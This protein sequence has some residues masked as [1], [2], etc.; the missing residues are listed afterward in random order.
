MTSAGSQQRAEN[1]GHQLS[2]TETCSGRTPTHLLLEH[3]F[4]LPALLVL[5]NRQYQTL[6]SENRSEVIAL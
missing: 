3:F 1:G 4:D 5:V 2:N 6:G